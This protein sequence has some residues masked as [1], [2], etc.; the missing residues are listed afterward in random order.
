MGAAAPGAAQQAGDAESAA[1][2]AAILHLDEGARAL[3]RPGQRL[4]LH[5]LQ[6]EALDR[7]VEHLADQIILFGIGDHAL[8]AAQGGG[9]LRPEGGPAAGDDHLFGAEAAHLAHF[10]ARI[11]DSGGGHGAGVHHRQVGLF[12]GGDQGVSGGA[13][14]A[15]KALDLSL[16]QPAADG[17]QIYLHGW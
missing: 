14:L 3:A 5:R 2:V 6:V 8:H 9:L 4:A 15:G 11:G 10:L 12:R 17:I 1:V 16:V 13:E 7:Q